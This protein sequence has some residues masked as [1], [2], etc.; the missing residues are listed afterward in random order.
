M[1]LTRGEWKMMYEGKMIYATSVDI[2]DSDAYLRV[3][4]V[5]SGDKLLLLQVGPATVLSGDFPDSLGGNK[6]GRL[7]R[8]KKMR[9]QRMILRVFAFTLCSV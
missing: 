8:E 3:Q 4:R 1:P 7:T 9:C 2:S 6:C 5:G